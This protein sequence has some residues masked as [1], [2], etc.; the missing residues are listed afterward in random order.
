MKESEV[1]IDGKD[2]Y[3]SIVSLLTDGKLYPVRR[4]CGRIEVVGDS[5]TAGEGLGGSRCDHVWEP[6]LSS[7]NPQY[8][9]AEYIG[10]YFR[11]NV[12]I[13]AQGGWGIYSSYDNRPAHAIPKI[14]PYICGAL[15]NT[16]GKGTGTGLLAKDNETDL[17]IINLGTNDA[18]AFTNPAWKDPDSEKVYKQR[19]NAAGKFEQEDADKVC[20]AVTDFL[21]VVRKYNPRAYIYWVY[22]MLKN[23]AEILIKKGIELYKIQAA[24]DKVKYIPLQDTTECEYGSFGHPGKNSHHQLAVRLI[25]EIERDA[26]LKR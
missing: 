15:S 25:E 26:I 10:A 17:V 14:Y 1:L 3:F 18:A 6:C 19:L 24:D 11:T 20:S 2:S 23:Q 5:I 21:E 13:V 4:L 8:H 12:S 9:Y 22:G 16:E 7:C